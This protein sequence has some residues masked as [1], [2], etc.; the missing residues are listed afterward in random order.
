MNEESKNAGKADD[1]AKPESSGS[2]PNFLPSSLNKEEGKAAEGL[3]LE[4][5]T[6]RVIGCAIAVHR[7]LGPGF[8]EGIYENALHVEFRHMGIPFQAQGEKPI[9][10]RG[11]LVGN[12]RFDLLVADQ[13]VVELKAIKALEDVHFAQVRSYLKALHL[14]HG[15]LFNFAAMPLAVKRVIYQ[16]GG[17]DLRS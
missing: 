12:H 3:E 11:H 10:Y 7:E 9:F 8:V 1:Q 16:G 4:D 17:P 14:K 13:L 15:L 5:L 2:V 6:G